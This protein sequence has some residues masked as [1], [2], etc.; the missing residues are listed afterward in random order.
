MVEHPHYVYLL[1][2]SLD[3]NVGILICTLYLFLCV[4]QVFAQI[5]GEIF[6]DMLSFKCIFCDFI[7]DI[8]YVYLNGNN[9]IKYEKL[10]LSHFS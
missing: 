9:D 8:N 1:H 3:V 2:A 4:I 5:T 10:Y 6:K 7:K